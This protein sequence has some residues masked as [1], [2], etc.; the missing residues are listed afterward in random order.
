M[1]S[2][3]KINYCELPPKNVYYQADGTGRDS[4]IKKNN[5]GFLITPKISKSIIGLFA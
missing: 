4:Y 3:L 1:I 5:G 2:R